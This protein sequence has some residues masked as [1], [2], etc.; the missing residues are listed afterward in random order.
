MKK[1]KRERTLEKEGKGKKL[2]RSAYAKFHGY[3]FASRII[4][5]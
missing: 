5:R 4:W 1:K 2:P 3:A